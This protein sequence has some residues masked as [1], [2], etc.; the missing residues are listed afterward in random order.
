MFLSKNKPVVF[1][2]LYEKNIII[3][4]GQRGNERPKK[5]ALKSGIRKRRKQERKKERNE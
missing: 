2:V 1:L 5:I 4:N 3:L